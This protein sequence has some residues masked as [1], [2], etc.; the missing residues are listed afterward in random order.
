ML[1]SEVPTMSANINNVDLII[2]YALLVAGEE[3]DSFDRQLG[4]IH[5]IKYVYLADIAFARRNEGQTFTGIDW[6]FYKFGP[7]AQAVNERIEPA[8]HAL[9]ADKQVFSSDYEDKDDWS[10]WSLRSERLLQEK[11]QNLP[12]YIV[13]SL[14]R[15]IH[16]FGKDTPSLLDH[17]YRT[18][19]MLVAAPNDY[20]DFASVVGDSFSKE[21][22]D[23]DT[24]MGSL[25]IK[26]KKKFKERMCALQ[27][28]QRSRE[29]KEPTL[30]NPVKNP[31]YDS[32]YADGITW[33]DELAGP[34]LTEGENVVEFSDEVWKS[35]T[36]RGEDVS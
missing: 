3:D 34:E 10:R 4:P 22:L 17:V 31:R 20:L 24:R 29:R 7:W 28:K 23:S 25:S 1:I 8:L 35:S 33:L 26:K 5:L 21:K 36:R 32:V 13:M 19:P 2:Q 18:K 6:Q 15:D 11:E 30:I 14:K 16:K 12:I 9:G 27:E